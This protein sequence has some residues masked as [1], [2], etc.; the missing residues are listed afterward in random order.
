MVAT[1]FTVSSAAGLTAALAQA[2][3][4]DKIVLASGNY[5]DV[6]L[7]GLTFSSNVSIVS[8]NPLSPATFNSI[9]LNRV[10]NLVLDSISI[11]F[12]PTRETKA[13]NAGIDIRSSS[14]ITVTNSHLEGGPSPVD[15]LLTARGISALW[16]TNITISNTEVTEF[17]RGI[18]AGDVDGLNIIDNNIHHN[19][20][21]T[22]S[23]SDVSNV[24]VS[25]NEFSSSQANNFGDGGTGDH[26]DF[27]HFWTS[28]SQ[29]VPSTNIVIRDNFLAQGDG[30][31]LLGIYLDDNQNLM[32]FTNVII[33]DNVIH[34][35]N[36]Q[37]IRMEDVNGLIIRN[38]K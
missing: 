25:G 30:T 3:G 38:N 31:A 10:T 28:T 19:R 6:S 11:D 8:A 27:I 12:T 17:R 14:N 15:G 32:G 29:T 22:L 34:N 9:S 4:G 23:G 21:S 13:F 5:G 36:A 16:S 26:G 20:T 1:I 2:S 33:E 18:F 37:A 7:S 35:G 24:L